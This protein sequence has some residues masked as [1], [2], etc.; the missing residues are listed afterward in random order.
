MPLLLLSPMPTTPSD[1]AIFKM[2]HSE[3]VK[4]ADAGRIPVIDD[5]RT[6]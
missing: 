6:G 1:P 2:T 4:T 5:R 3:I